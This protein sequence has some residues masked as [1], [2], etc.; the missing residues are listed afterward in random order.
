MPGAD[1][2][3]YVRTMRRLREPPVEI[4]HGGHDPS[5]GRTRL[6][7]IVDDYLRRRGA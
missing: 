2:A 3:A 6:V 1:V 5:F 4:V 7:E